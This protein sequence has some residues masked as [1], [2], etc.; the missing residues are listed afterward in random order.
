MSDTKLRILKLVQDEAAKQ[1]GEVRSRQVL[2]MIKVFAEE[3]DTINERISQVL[4]WS[5]D[6]ADS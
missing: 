4:F 1:G 3:I 5:D 2:A 6:G